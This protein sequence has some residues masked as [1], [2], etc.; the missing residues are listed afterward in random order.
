MACKTRDILPVKLLIQTMIIHAGN[1]F[2]GV[3]IGP[4]T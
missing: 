1:I 4:G 3:D 2:K